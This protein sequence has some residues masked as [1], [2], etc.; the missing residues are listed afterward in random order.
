MRRDAGAV[1]MEILNRKQVSWA[2]RDQV[3]KL[4]RFSPSS[5]SW[6]RTNSAKKPTGGNY[7]NKLLRVYLF[8]TCLAVLVLFLVLG[9]SGVGIQGLGSRVSV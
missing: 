8:L 4:H 5:E 9:F 1:A 7:S 3:P 6:S 2:P